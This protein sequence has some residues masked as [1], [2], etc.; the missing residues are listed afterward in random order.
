MADWKQIS[1][2]SSRLSYVFLYEMPEMPKQHME[3]PGS[4]VPGSFD[5]RRRQSLTAL[6]EA[7]SASDHRN[8]AY[9]ASEDSA[10]T[11]ATSHDDR[12]GVSACQHDH[13]SQLQHVGWLRKFFRIAEIVCERRL[14]MILGLSSVSSRWSTPVRFK[15][16]ISTL[17]RWYKEPAPDSFD[18]VVV[19]MQL[20]WACAFTLHSDD[21]SYCWAAFFQDMLEWQHAIRNRSE[22][23]L[24]ERLVME[25]ACDQGF[26]SVSSAA[27]CATDARSGG[28]IMQLLGDGRVV[29]ECSMFLKG[30][31]IYRRAYSHQPDSS[32]SILLCAYL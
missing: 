20:A 25:W 9:S 12:D 26:S 21:D 19:L 15:M 14:Q 29:Q 1:Y 23:L 4:V 6:H 2:S 31:A 28:T 30:K 3:L 17:Q 18:N 27:A 24:F 8:T 13:P 16:G 32:P 10:T 7:P 5:P 11:N 22:K